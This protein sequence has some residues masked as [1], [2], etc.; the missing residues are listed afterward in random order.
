M[1][2]GLLSPVGAGFARFGMVAIV[3]SMR[4]AMIVSRYWVQ[5]ISLV[6]TCFCCGTHTSFASG[7]IQSCT[8]MARIASIHGTVANF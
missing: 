4:S 5:K 3:E 2:L 8:Q 6:R 1:R 7:S